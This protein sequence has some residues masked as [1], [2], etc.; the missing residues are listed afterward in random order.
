[1]H[2]LAIELHPVIYFLSSFSSWTFHLFVVYHGCPGLI[3][4]IAQSQTADYTKSMQGN[5]T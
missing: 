4:M 3:I 5:A 1:M 2:L